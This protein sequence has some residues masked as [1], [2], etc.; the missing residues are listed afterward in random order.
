M[1]LWYNGVLPKNKM[2]LRKI[3]LRS[4]EGKKTVMLIEDVNTCKFLKL[5]KSKPSFILITKVCR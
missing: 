3:Y 1:K 2:E 4:F 5:T